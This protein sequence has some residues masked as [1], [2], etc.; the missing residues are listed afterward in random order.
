MVELSALIDRT[1]AGDGAARDELFSRL[2]DE[3]RRLAHKRLTFAARNTLLDTSALLHET[4]LRMAKSNDLRF[5]DHGRYFAYASQV[6]RGVVVD[7]ARARASQRR[8]GG[9]AMVTLNTDI[10]HAAAA[11][12]RQILR[13]HEAL[14]E[15]LCI[16]ERMVRVVEMRYFAGLTEQEVALAL[17]VTDRTVRR[18]WEKARYLLAAAMTEGAQDARPV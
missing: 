18:I 9:R 13:I 16:D 17:G 2:Y 1:D 8:G 6:M 15:L 12:E 5:E 10:V 14:D 4:Y 7:F 3:L 11:D